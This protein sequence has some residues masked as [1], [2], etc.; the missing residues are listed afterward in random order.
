MTYLRA[1]IVSFKPK[2][3]TLKQKFLD[4]FHP[5][6]NVSLE[7]SH[8]VLRLQVLPRVLHALD[9]VG[10]GRVVLDEGALV[11][12][13]FGYTQRTREWSETW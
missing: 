5:A 11:P 6:A 1:G 10:L 9:V 8:R 3:F 4:L 12:N 2:L 13:E 7:L